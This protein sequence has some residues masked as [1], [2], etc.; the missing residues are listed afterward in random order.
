MIQAMPD[1]HYMGIVQLA[2]FKSRLLMLEQILQVRVRGA[3]VAIKNGAAGADPV[4][5]AT[6]EEIHTMALT[7]RARDASQLIAVRAA[8]AGIEL[9]EFGYCKESGEPIGVKRLL[10]C[11]TAGYTT[12]V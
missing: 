4:D 5:R 1:A 10:V 12:E 8:M 2:F 6:A 11:P 9:G 3:D 7:G